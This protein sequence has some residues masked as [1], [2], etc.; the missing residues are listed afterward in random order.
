MD[1]GIGRCSVADVTIAAQADFVRN[2]NAQQI[3][4]LSKENTTALWNAV[5]DSTACPSL[6]PC[7][8]LPSPPLQLFFSP[9][10]FGFADIIPPQHLDDYAAFSKVNARLLNTSRELKNVPIRVYIPQSPEDATATSTGGQAGSFK[11]VQTLVQPRVNDRMYCLLRG[12]GVQLVPSISFPSLLSP[13]LP[14]STFRLGR[15][16]NSALLLLDSFRSALP[17]C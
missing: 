11:V 4:S 8:A 15:S 16:P 2:G 9:R 7:P 10:V 17:S 5:Q 3:M 6:L 1:D 14:L 12:G 13:P